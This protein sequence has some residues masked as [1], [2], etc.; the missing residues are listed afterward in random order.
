MKQI[1][2][3]TVR[4]PEELHRKLKKKARDK[5]L[6]VNAYIVSTLWKQE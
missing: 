6:T 2:Q 3:I 1:K 4:L 5:G